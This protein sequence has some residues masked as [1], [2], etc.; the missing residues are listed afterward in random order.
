MSEII[1]EQALLNDKITSTSRE[2]ADLQARARVLQLRRDVTVMTARKLA[3]HQGL[4]SIFRDYSL[5][6]LRMLADAEVE[7][8][9]DYLRESPVAN[10]FI[11]NRLSIDWELA[12]QLAS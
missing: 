11:C 9:R 1:A 4:I 8:I 5:D 6:V 7:Q 10:D 3:W 12:R 2:L